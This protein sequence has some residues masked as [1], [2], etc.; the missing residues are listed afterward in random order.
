MIGEL[1]DLA[2]RRKTV[3]IV[4]GRGHIRKGRRR[5]GGRRRKR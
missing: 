4:S 2:E 3:N 1:G 5:K